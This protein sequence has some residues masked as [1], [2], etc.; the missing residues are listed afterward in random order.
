MCGSFGQRAGKLLCGGDTEIRHG[1]WD[2]GSHRCIE[3][4]Y[5]QREEEAQEFGPERSL[6]LLR[7]GQKGW[8]RLEGGVSTAGSHTT[9]A[10]QRGQV[11]YGRELGH[12]PEFG[13]YSRCQEK[14]DQLSDACERPL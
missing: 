7:D 3:Q 6:G 8:S 10:G 14:P 11:R 5:R 4:D 2:K 12:G 9:L 13:F 1:R